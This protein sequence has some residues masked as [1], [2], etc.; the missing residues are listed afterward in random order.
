AKAARPQGRQGTLG[1]VA[2]TPP[3]PGESAVKQELDHARALW[4]TRGMNKLSTDR[5]TQLVA[6][7]VEG[8]SI[9]ATARMTDTA[10]NTVLKFVVDMGRASAKFLDE[11]M[12]NIPSKRIQCDEIWQFCYAK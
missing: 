9:R 2:R 6:A 3:P 1:E 11:T 10:F 4:H 8:N 5:R 12:V 7:L